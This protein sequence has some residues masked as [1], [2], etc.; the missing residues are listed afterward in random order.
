MFRLITSSQQESQHFRVN[1]DIP[2]VTAHP[3]SA[4]MFHSTVCSPMKIQTSMHVCVYVWVLTVFTLDSCIVRE[5]KNSES[6]LKS[7]MVQ[8][9]GC[10]F[11]SESEIMSICSRAGVLLL[12]CIQAPQLA[13][14]IYSSFTPQMGGRNYFHRCC[15]HQPCLSTNLTLAEQWRMA[16]R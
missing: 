9:S 16:W 6:F 8:S 11:V 2:L 1:R 10:V 13:G 4:K 14:P 7:S 5:M 12:V 3:L 15:S